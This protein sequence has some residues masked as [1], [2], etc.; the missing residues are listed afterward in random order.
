MPNYVVYSRRPSFR[1]SENHVHNWEGGLNGRLFLLD[2]GCIV[3]GNYFSSFSSEG[4][5]GKG[6]TH[7]EL[8]AIAS[9][10]LHNLLEQHK[11]ELL[12]G[13]YVLVEHPNKE[14]TM[15]KLLS[16]KDIWLE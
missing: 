2:N 7:D 4:I 16:N 13:S 8:D 5:L 3:Y 9:G 6:I 1:K 15:G 11:K 14:T 10:E 12:N